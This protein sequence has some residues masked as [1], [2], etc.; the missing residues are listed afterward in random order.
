MA[1]PQDNGFDAGPGLGRLNVKRG[2]EEAE[3][4]PALQ[5]LGYPIPEPAPMEPIPARPFFTFARSLYPDFVAA[6]AAAL[7]ETRDNALE[8]IRQVRPSLYEKLKA[9]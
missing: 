1:A 9:N 4:T 2:C 6:L 3:W 8:K 5:A 7:P